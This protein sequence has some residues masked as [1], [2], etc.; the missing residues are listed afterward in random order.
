MR[1]PGQVRRSVDAADDPARD[2]ALVRERCVFTTHTPIEA[3]YEKVSYELV[4][5][6]LADLQDTS[7]WPSLSGSPATTDST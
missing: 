4:T 7:R 6:T 5:K 3:G 2:V 1:S